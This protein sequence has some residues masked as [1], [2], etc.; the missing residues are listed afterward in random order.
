MIR[1]K[2]FLS[3]IIYLQ[4]VFS[5]AAVKCRPVELHHCVVMFSLLDNRLYVVYILKK[6]FAHALW[7][8]VVGHLSLPLMKSFNKTEAAIFP[9]QTM[10]P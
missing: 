1:N 5:V 3:R 4:H 6:S 7:E 10:L 9:M 2:T 8:S